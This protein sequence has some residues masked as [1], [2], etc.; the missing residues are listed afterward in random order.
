MNTKIF[1]EYDIRGEYGKDFNEDFAY[2][3]GRSYASY[4]QE[5]YKQNTVIVGRDN[6]LSSPILSEYLI[7]GLLESGATV[8]KLGLVTSPMCAYA[9]KK[10]H[11]VFSIMITASHNPKEDNGFKFSLDKYGMAR[12]EMIDEFKN[13]TLQNK[14]LDKEGTLKTIDIY[15]YYI[16]HIASNIHLGD[17]KIKVILDPAN[18]TTSPFLKDIFNEL[19]IDYKIINKESDGNFPTHHPDPS[20][21]SNL[22]QLRDEVLNNKADL[23][24]GYDGDGD[25]LG[26]IDELGTFIPADKFMIIAVRDLINKTDDKRFLFDVKSSKA[27]E[28][29]II[30]LG[31]TP[32]CYRV[33][34]HSYIRTKVNKDG[35]IFG[36]ELSGHIVYNDR[37]DGI[38]DGT[39]ASLRLIE[40]LSKTDKPLSQLLNGITKYYNTPEIKIKIKD[41]IKFQIVETIKQQAIEK[42]YTINDIDG[43]RITFEDSWVL[44]RASNTGP[45]LTVRFEA[46]T[47]EKLESLKKEYLDLIETLNK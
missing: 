3:L 24:I 44:V 10:L 22:S 41:E 6:R 39:Y 26:I 35:I 28:D 19:N 17:K 30:K 5:K 20:I 12:G 21:E 8:I 2:I 23:G 40:I 45:N 4:I 43:V 42:N 33:G 29:E 27:L 18:G 11:N 14:F 38:D 1:R 36:G 34:G 25:R 15:P 31:G 16:S 7:K 13:Y 46:Q 9:T 47:E 32:I 37:C